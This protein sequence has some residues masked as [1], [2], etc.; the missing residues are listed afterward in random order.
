MSLDEQLPVANWPTES[1]E[2]KVVQLELDGTPHLRFAEGRPG[3]H[4]VILMKLFS[5]RDV[6][7]GEIE[8]MNGWR[9]PE[10]Q[11]ERYKVHGMGTSTV[12]VE[13]RRAS[14][15]GKSLDYDIGIDTTH[16]DSVRPLLNDWKLE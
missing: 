8:L 15:H 5:D 7:Y 12:N 2:Y 6:Q 3:S 13:Q 14:F 11:G 9:I 16:L 4:A 10:L 1:G